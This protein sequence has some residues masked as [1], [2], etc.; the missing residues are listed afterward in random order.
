MV[1]EFT[2][3]QDFKSP[4]I[5]LKGNDTAYRLFKRGDLFIGEKITLE[6]GKVNDDVYVNKE[7]WMIPANKLQR[8]NKQKFTDFKHYDAEKNTID[9]SE[10]PPEIQKKIDEIAKRNFSMSISKEMAKNF[11]MPILF[12]GLGFVW[13]MYRGTNV[14]MGTIGGVIIGIIING[15]QKPKAEKQVEEV[16]KEEEKPKTTEEEK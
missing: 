9:T 2:L 11:K 3:T 1:S 13:S 6:K 14:Y 5:K 8:R 12:G 16:I 10:F 15:L 7:Q 4:N